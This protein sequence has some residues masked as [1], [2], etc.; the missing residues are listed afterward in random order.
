MNDESWQSWA[1]YYHPRLDTWCSMKA[2]GPYVSERCYKTKQSK[3]YLTQQL[4]LW[5][6]NHME[7]GLVHLVSQ[8]LLASLYIFFCLATRQK[9][10]MIGD[11][12]A[13]PRLVDYQNA[14]LFTSK[15]TPH[16][17]T[18]HG[19][20]SHEKRLCVAWQI[21]NELAHFPW[22]RQSQPSIRIPKS[23][24]HSI[25]F[26]IKVVLVRIVWRDD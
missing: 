7:F 13:P 16:I 20:V 25:Y 12:C 2:N 4:K 26:S 8:T 23:R 18:S 24:A 10:Y 22:L 21:Y 1:Y 14:E 11:P 9:G 6:H 3:V 17:C 19:F 15:T 5:W